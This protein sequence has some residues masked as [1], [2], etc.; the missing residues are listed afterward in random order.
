M[1]INNIETIEQKFQIEIMLLKQQIEALQGVIQNYE[2]L[3][4]LA[5]HKRFGRSSEKH[6]IT[7]QISMFDDDINKDEEKTSEVEPVME[8]VTY[9]R[10][11]RKGFRKEQYEGLP[12]ETIVYSLPMEDQVCDCCSGQLHEMSK[13]IRK[14]VVIVPAQLKIV[15]H[16]KIVYGCRR[17]EKEE[18]SVPIKTATAPRPALPGSPASASAIAYVMSQKFVE[19]MPLYRME[20]HFERMGIILSRQTMSNW[21]LSAS[22][23]WLKQLYDYLKKEL[24]KL[25]IL[26]CD[27]T[28]LQVLSEPGKSAQSKS[29][30]WLYRSGIYDPPIILYD[31]QPSRAGECPKKFLEGYSGYGHVDGYKGYNKVK[32]IILSACWAH[33]RRAFV[34][35][36]KALPKNISKDNIALT[37]SN[38]GLEYCDKLFEIERLLKEFTPE[39][40][41]EERLKRSK[42]LLEEFK[43]WLDYYYIRT[44][45]KS[46]AGKAIRYCINI[47]NKLIVFLKDGRLEISNNRA[48][49]TIKSLVLSRKNFLFCKTQRGANACA[50]IFSIVETAKE[51]SLNPFEYL[52][53]LFEKMPNID[54]L[55][56]E[57]FSQLVPWA[58]D[59]PE[60]VKVPKKE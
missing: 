55:N 60:S 43:V 48:E 7:N 27:E 56:D 47:W 42:P 3:L 8:Q 6:I 50:V 2:E 20:K 1:T 24:L 53:Y 34:D 21:L 41:Y 32:N 39:L 10:R 28:E 12:I 26:H 5:A 14:E 29:Y 37:I 17:C 58:A 54:I 38:K 49:R 22:E 33:A 59:L 44:L 51:N 15:E 16:V 13:E 35:A 11:K 4:R 25:D 45:P 9:K 19:C 18:I 36:L 31:Y 40:R 57:V 23:K 46:P 30:M 52:K